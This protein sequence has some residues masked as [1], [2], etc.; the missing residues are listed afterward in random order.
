M[1]HSEDSLMHGEEIKYVAKKHFFLFVRPIIWL[2]LGLV[3]YLL[4]I[5]V[6]HYIG[7]LV[8]LKGIHLFIKRLLIK[9]S[10]SYVLTNKRLIFKT[11][12]TSSSIAKLVLAK[13]E[14]LSVKQS[15]LG[16]IF[17]FGTI[18]VTTGGVTNFYSF[19]ANP[20]EFWHKI[21]AQIG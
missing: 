14:G 1:N 21:N 4:K 18:I 17:G 19:I 5:S 20:T 13:C 3:L 10:S 7:I 8:L 6:L 16:K 15:F 2:L 9:I 11:G 12:I